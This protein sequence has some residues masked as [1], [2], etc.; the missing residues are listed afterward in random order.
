MSGDVVV[1][2]GI[3]GLAVAHELQSA[4]GWWCW[5]RSAASQNTQPGR[6]SGVIH[7]GLYNAPGSR[8]AAMTVGGAGSMRNSDR[9]YGVA[10]DI[11]GKLVV[12]SNEGQVPALRRLLERGQWCAGA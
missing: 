3:I 11:C 4:I 2:A 10:V 5:K 12:A 7:S 9:G 6:N 8:K 1:G